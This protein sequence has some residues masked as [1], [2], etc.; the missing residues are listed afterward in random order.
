[1][2]AVLQGVISKDDGLREA[3]EIVMTLKDINSGVLEIRSSEYS[4]RIGI[5]WGRFITGAALDTGERGKVALR[6]LLTLRSG[7]FSFVDTKGEPVLELRQALGV[8]LN[9]V[10]PYIPDINPTVTPWLYEQKEQ[11]DAFAAAAADRDRKKLADEQ[12]APAASLSAPSTSQS[13]QSTASA[14]SS[15]GSRQTG[16]LAPG[17]LRRKLETLKTSTQPAEIAPSV[18]LQVEPNKESLSESAKSSPGVDDNDKNE[19]PSSYDESVTQ[20]LL[21]YLSVPSADDDD[22]A[23]DDEPFDQLTPPASES[24]SKIKIEKIPAQGQLPQ[25]D[26]ID[27]KGLPRRPKFASVD[28]L[29]TKNRPPIESPD[30]T[31][32]PVDASFWPISE[33]GNNLKSNNKNTLQSKTVTPAPEPEPYPF[34]E[35][36]ISSE[37]QSFTVADE[38]MQMGVA[39][40]VY[41]ASLSQSDER[42]FHAPNVERQ[43][44]KTKAPYVQGSERA[45]Q[46]PVETNLLHESQMIFDP[47]VSPLVARM[48]GDELTPHFAVRPP[49]ATQAQELEPKLVEAPM[50]ET[51]LRSITDAMADTIR[52]E[53]SIAEQDLSMYPSMHPT[54]TMPHTALPTNGAVEQEPPAARRARRASANSDAVGIA[55]F[56]FLF[57]LVSC[58]ATIYLGTKFFFNH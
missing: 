6:K 16:P 47:S 50:P 17:S 31:K 39:E 15:P 35:L 22:S 14:P 54:P 45:Q 19:Q 3:V 58:L 23:D 53:P 24:Q 5:A 29:R 30:H 13:T 25:D 33:G 37:S 36:V 20:A 4:G 55:I 10:A 42:I 12:S 28:Q 48:V 38:N 40:A 11:S 1:M 32:P 18:A 27:Y 26:D 21:D 49:A 9:G 2:P 41:R 7:R 57:F 56:S 8:D 52:R 44:P 46:H 51:Q 34:H 43:K